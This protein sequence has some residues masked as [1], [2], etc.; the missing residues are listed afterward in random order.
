MAEK[1]LDKVSMREIDEK[2]N[3][4]KPVVY[5]YFKNK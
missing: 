5:Y 1:G 2:V 4:N 3:V